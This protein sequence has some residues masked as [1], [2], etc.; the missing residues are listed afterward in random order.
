MTEKTERPKTKSTSAASTTSTGVTNAGNGTSEMMMAVNATAIDVFT[1]ACR[2]GFCGWASMNSE[3]ADFM[4]KRLKHDA[5][6]SASLARCET[7]E[8]AVALQRDWAREAA[9]EY[10]D[11][12]NRLMELSS[13]LASDQWKPVWEQADE[14]VSTMA[15]NAS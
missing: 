14:M 9:E 7:W 4:A 5:D 2:A 10:M 13:R 3:V 15:K 6:L 8:D 12:A 11:E 1:R